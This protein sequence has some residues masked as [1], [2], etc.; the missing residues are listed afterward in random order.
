MADPDTLVPREILG[1]TADYLYVRSIVRTPIYVKVVG[2]S[3]RSGTMGAAQSAVTAA[4]DK[5]LRR[6]APFVQGLDPDFDRLDDVTATNLGR[7]VQDSL[8]P[9]GGSAQNVLLG[10]SVGTY[11]GHY[12]L[13][14]NERL[15]LGGIIFEAGA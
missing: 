5:H 3:V 4:S 15:K 11:L 14:Q 1:L 10:T 2:L 8:E 12:A 7:E 13:A 9:Y 6:F